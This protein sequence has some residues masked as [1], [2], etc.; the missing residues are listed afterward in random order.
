M[1]RKALIVDDNPST[2]KTIIATLDD[3]EMP[4]VLTETAK[5]ALD[6]L[7]DDDGISVAFVRGF[8]QDVRGA[9]LCRDIRKTKSADEVSVLVILTEDQL[10]SGAEAL[11]AGATDLLIAPFEPRELRMRAN[12]V[13]A[14]QLRRVDQAHTIANQAA[15]QDVQP[16]LF[17]PDFD[18]E[19]KRILGAGIVGRN[20]GELIGE[21]F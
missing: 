20:A 3:A 14:D 18:P 17:I 8:G 12:I 5:G 11:I 10:V 1:N 4:Y 7:A 16:G 21:T 9:D 6:I 13:P 15:D 2:V 19:T